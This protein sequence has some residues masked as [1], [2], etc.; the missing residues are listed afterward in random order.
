[1]GVGDE[2]VGFGGLRRED[3]VLVFEGLRWVGLVW[4]RERLLE[5]EEGRGILDRCGV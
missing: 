2:R 4:K 5:F 1:M 3:R